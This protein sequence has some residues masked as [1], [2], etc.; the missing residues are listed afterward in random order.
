M[1]ESSGASLIDLQ[2]M[3]HRLIAVVEEQAQVLLRTAFSPIVRE[4]GDL[5]A[6]VFDLKGRML[7]QAV[8][9]TPG[10]V[11]SMA[12]SVKHFI[13][14]FPHQT[15][16]PGDAYITNDP[17]MGTGHL[18]DF[19]VTTPC[20][21]DGKA[22]ALF[23]CTSHLMDIG[24]IGFGPDATDVFMEGLYI[25]MLKLIDQGVVNETLMA[26]IRSNTRLP[27]D[28]EGDTYS[29][30][31][32]NDVGCQRLVEMMREFE[33][34]SL[35]TLGDFICDR[36]REAVLAEI[37]K[38]PKGVWRNS[39]V[40]DG[41]DAPVTLAATLTISEEGIHVDFDG[42]SGASKFGINV[43]H[44]YTIA[45]TV[46]G[47]GCVVASQIPNNAGSLSPLTV[48][49]PAGCDPQ[50]A[51]AGAGGVAP[52]HRPDAARRGVRLPAS[53]HSRAGAGRRHVLP[54]ESQCARTDAQRRRRQLRIL[55]GGDEQR[56]HRRAFC[57]GWI[58]GHGLSQRRTRHAGRDRGDA[59]AVDLL[60]QGAASGF[61]AAP[62]ARAA[63]SARSSKSAAASMLRSTFWRPSTASI[64]RPAAVTAAVTAKP[65]MSG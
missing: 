41:Y 3:W 14:H 65:A 45:Y 18:N 7:A 9:G 17:W 16:K 43:P 46:F 40:V 5:S 6:G 1:N 55:D 21:K 51:E 60:A 30:A 27:I 52:C 36:S 29:L 56:R 50:C 57:Q 42:T 13:A 19:V 8:T 37:A 48:A 25:P 2:I 49:A 63:V 12:E 53:D 4:C 61:R 31:G 64:I 23:S 24:G 33:I 35:D 26:M 10:H 62:A 34:Y 11:N 59:D 54:V 32:C 44:S 20:F 22:V 28:T 47:L 58:V 39:M 38:L 15:M